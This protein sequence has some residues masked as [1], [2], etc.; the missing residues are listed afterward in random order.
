[1]QKFPIKTEI[2]MDIAYIF[3]VTMN[4]I[5][6]IIQKMGKKI[7]FL[8][9]FLLV[10]IN[11]SY[12]EG[13]PESRIHAPEVST[14]ALLS[15]GIFGW[16]VRFAR[17]RFQEFKRVFDITV[18]I[19]G[20]V[21]TAPLLAMTALFIKIVSPGSAIFKQE[22]M[23]LDGTV[24]N[25]YKLRTMKVDAEKETGAVWAEENDPRL[26]KFGKIIRKAHIDEL[27][28]L[29][30]VLKGEMS[31]VG[32]RPERPVFVKE[33]KDKIPSYVARLAVK[34]GI[35]GLAQV[36]HKYDETIE[37]VKK[38]I[39]YDLLYIKKMCLMA[40]LRILANTIVVVLTGK[41]AR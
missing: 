38:K 9:L 26:I 41:G 27:P 22:R 34:P 6:N 8:V 7:L 17:K 35:T 19:T 14:V 5:K 36:W 39:K 32:P 23:G 37:D 40:D 10:M 12:A 29:I 18:S 3:Y 20:L 4:T 21:I 30:N 15:T 11:I 25:I 31:I 28:Q 16:V 1:M 33:L 2:G 24:F 13:D